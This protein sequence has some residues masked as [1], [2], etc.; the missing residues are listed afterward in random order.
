[1]VDVKLFPWLVLGC[2]ISAFESVFSLTSIEY[3][4]DL[5]QLP[6]YSFLIRLAPVSCSFSRG[7]VV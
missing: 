2:M 7:G 5:K 6:F 3:P 1:M 4:V